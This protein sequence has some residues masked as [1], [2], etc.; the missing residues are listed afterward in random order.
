MPR[1]SAHV[2]KT[3]SWVARAP[4][5]GVSS[6]QKKRA[7][8]SAFENHLRDRYCKLPISGC[9]RVA[10]SLCNSESLSLGFRGFLLRH[11]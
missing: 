9:D 2:D 1:A 7:K 11:W 5:L 8:S 4:A 6:L 3:P 10:R